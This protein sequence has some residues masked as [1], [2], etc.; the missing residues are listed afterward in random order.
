MGAIIQ[1]EPPAVSEIV[2]FT[3]DGTVSVNVNSVADAKLAIKAFRL[4]RKELLAA[5]RQVRT[6][7]MDVRA[8]YRSRVAQRGTKV[9]GAN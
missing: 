4:K 2:S 1:A 7:I 5:K 9:R 8:D 3:P 6:A